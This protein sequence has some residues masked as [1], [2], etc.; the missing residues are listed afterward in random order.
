MDF[1]DFLKPTVTI[2]H[3]TQTCCSASLRCS[4]DRRN[5]RRGGFAGAQI[6]NLP[7]LDQE[8][9]H[10]CWAA[11][12]Y[13]HCPL[14][15]SARYMVAMRNREHCPTKSGLLLRS[16]ASDFNLCNR[17]GYLRTGAQ[18]HPVLRIDDRARSGVRG[19]P[20]GAEPGSLDRLPGRVD[21]RRSALSDIER[22]DSRRIG[23]RVHRR[24][25]PDPQKR[26]HRSFPVRLRTIKAAPTGHTVI[27]R[28]PSRHREA[29]RPTP[30][31]GS[32]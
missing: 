11:R 25:R 6:L 32:I 18:D 16:C 19:H 28:D 26:A 8:Q 2:S 17:D 20:S 29:R 22:L 15:R 13:E 3:T 30:V 24:Q 1:P 5:R 9:G 7:D 23:D 10:W 14:L 31:Q 4:D 12:R 27:E 21:R